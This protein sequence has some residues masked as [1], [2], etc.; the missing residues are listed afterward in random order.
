MLKNQQYI[1][2]KEITMEQF[3]SGLVA[4]FIFN[5]VIMAIFKTNKMFVPHWIFTLSASVFYFVDFNEGSID[6]SPISNTMLG[7]IAFDFIVAFFK[8]LKKR[9][10]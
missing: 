9:A 5:L 10:K 2:I 8:A 3:F 4:R 7:F 6:V 1:T